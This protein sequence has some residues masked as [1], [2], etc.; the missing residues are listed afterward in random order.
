MNKYGIVLPSYAYS[1]ERGRLVRDAMWSLENT[2]VMESKPK[3]LMILRLS[4]FYKQSYVTQK[5]LEKFDVETIADPGTIGGTEQTLAWGTQTLFDQGVEYVTWMGDD[6]LFH[7]QWHLKLQKLIEDK[8]EALGWSVYR[9]AYEKYHRTLEETNGYV[10][11]STLCGHGMTISS[12]EWKLWGIDWRQGSWLSAG[13][14]TLDLH[15]ASQREGER[16]TTAVSYV[17]H[18][19]RSGVHCSPETPEWAVNFQGQG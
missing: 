14:D 4:E 17:E 18:T 12:Q 2:E 13:A 16:W 9:S 1:T 5:L 19:G 3:L 7:P 6:A 15:H 8:P 10:R 11:V